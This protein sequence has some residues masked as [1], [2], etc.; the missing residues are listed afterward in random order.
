MEFRIFYLP[1][2]KIYEDILVGERGNEKW[3][4]AEWQPRLHKWYVVNWS[5]DF[6]DAYSKLKKYEKADIK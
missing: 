3:I 6:E 5:W 4:V 2:I 1:P